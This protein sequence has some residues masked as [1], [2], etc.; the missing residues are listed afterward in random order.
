MANAY[1]VL[2]GMEAPVEEHMFEDVEGDPNADDI[3]RISPNGLEITTGTSATTY[4]PGDPVLRG[5]MALFLTRLYKAATGEDAPAG[6]TPF[7]DIGDRPDAEQAAIGSLFELEV[8]RGTS[9][10]TYSPHSNVTREQMASFVARMYRAIDEMP[11]PTEAPGA[12]TGVMAAVSGDDGDALDV[13]W[14]APED[15]GTSDVTGYVVQWKSGDDDYSEDNQRSVDGMMSMFDGLTKGMT[16][17]FRVAAMSDDGQSDWSDE[18]SGTPATVPGAVSNLKVTAGNKTLSVT[19]DAPDDGGSTVTG[20]TVEWRSGREGG[21]M[22]EAEGDALGYTITLKKNEG[23]YLVTVTPMNAV[24]AGDPA[25]VNPGAN[26]TPT[27]GKST[28]PSGL[29]LAQMVA[30]DGAVSVTASWSE[31]SDTGGR[32]IENYEIRHRFKDR[33]T[34]S[35]G[36]WVPTGDTW[37]NVILPDPLTAVISSS[38][39]PVPA[40]NYGDTLEV[41]VRADNL[42]SNTSS[43][44]GLSDA[45]KAS[46]VPSTVPDKPATPM[47]GVANNSLQVSW[48]ASSKANDGGSAVTGYKVSYS[49][50]GPSTT[51]SVGADTTTRT[52]TGLDKRFTYSV[53]VKAVNANGDSPASD[54]ASGSPAQVPAAPTNLRV[55]VPPAFE[56]DGTTPNADRATSL[57]VSWSAPPN[58]GTSA[59]TGYRVQQRTS[60]IPGMNGAADTPAGDWASA[61]TEPAASPITASTTKVTITGLPKGVPHDVRVQA[62]ND[63]D[64]DTDGVQLDP[65][66]PYA[67]VSATPATV[68]SAVATINLAT[69][70]RSLTVNWSPAENNG[71]KVTHYLLRYADATTNQGRW[72]SDIRVDASKSPLVHVLTG[73]RADTNYVVQV[74]AVNGIGT[75]PYHDADGSA[76]GIQDPSAATGGVPSAPSNVTAVSKKDGDGSALTVTW[77]RVTASN[78]GGPLMVYVAETSSDGFTWG[79]ATLNCDLATTEATETCSNNVT[80]GEISDLTAGSDYYVRVAA[81]ANVVGSYGYSAKVTATAVPASPSGLEVAY[82]ATAKGLKVTWTA[83]S[84]DAAKALTG[85]YRLHWFPSVAGAPGDTGV[86]T[87]PDGTSGSYVITGISFTP[88]NIYSVRLHALNSVGAS[89]G[90]VATAEA[91]P[92]S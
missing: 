77:S 81:M 50:G 40:A 12:P 72:S 30:A 90:I 36:D 45:A 88:G 70:Y 31:P 85:G 9:A 84:G 51:V 55:V 75:G 68:P 5:H 10:T 49:S 24:G 28:A 18:A 53:T 11:D 69:G 56:A 27:T 3:A 92:A 29:K 19:W 6:D 8:T 78:G 86:A 2:T 20:Y 14:M 37:T 38:P 58:N 83:L 79:A 41:E 16:Y 61:T 1:A 34:G 21:E 73:L 32:D 80:K 67:T 76:E 71:S 15:S 4:S 13:S 64:P 46:I 54:A 22:A 65:G 44:T 25:S 42:A 82:D 62:V 60:F 26:T 52:L 87:I 59:V 74:R 89:G 7:T 17:M 57:D 48:T 43:D 33:E 63:S 39:I 47:I 35:A 66:G 23:Q 91:I